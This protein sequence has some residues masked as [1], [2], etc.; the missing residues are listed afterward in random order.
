MLDLGR[1]HSVINYTD[2]YRYHIIVHGTPNS[3]VGVHM[4]R[5]MEQL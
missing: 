3:Q 4:K 5:S 2:E 1:R